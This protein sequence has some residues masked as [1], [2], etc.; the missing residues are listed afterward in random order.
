MGQRDRI[1]LLAGELYPGCEVVFD[2][3]AEGRIRFYIKRGVEML[4]RAFPHFTEAELDLR[5][6]DEL[7]KLIRKLCNQRT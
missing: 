3:D 1:V 6:D 4:S 5:S 7:R 2:D